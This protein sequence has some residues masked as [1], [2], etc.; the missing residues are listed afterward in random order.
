MHTFQFPLKIPF[1]KCHKSTFPTKEFLEKISLHLNTPL[2][3][4]P[5][6]LKE[7]LME[8][9]GL[10][11]KECQHPECQQL[12]SEEWLYILDIHTILEYG[13][14][15][16]SES[17]PCWKHWYCSLFY[18]SN[19]AE[20]ISDISQ[21][22]A[23][24]QKTPL[25]VIESF[26]L[27]DHPEVCKMIEV[28]CFPNTGRFVFQLDSFH[29]AIQPLKTLMPKTVWAKLYIGYE[30]HI[31]EISNSTAN[32]VFSCALGLA[33]L[34][35][36]LQEDST[37]EQLENFLVAHTDLQNSEPADFLKIFQEKIPYTSGQHQAHIPLF[38]KALPSIPSEILGVD[39]TVPPP[40]ALN[41]FISEV[42]HFCDSQ[43]LEL[44]AITS[45]GVLLYPRSEEISYKPYPC[46]CRFVSKAPHQPLGFAHLGQFIDHFSLYHCW[47]EMKI[48]PFKTF[49]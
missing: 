12:K 8:K 39:I 16:L 5:I 47:Q 28:F 18:P 9:W 2:Q 29:S 46:T 30:K 13:F 26:P 11:L 35:R 43:V 38:K 7:H 27:Q 25:K 3:F 42:N 1:Q 44:S 15:P 36:H 41:S 31:L 34:L 21:T 4:I 37:A 49:L 33:T 14:S 6:E 17:I 10:F 40:I 32:Q 19:S 23:Q 24:K 20:Q 48:L 45:Q 22:W